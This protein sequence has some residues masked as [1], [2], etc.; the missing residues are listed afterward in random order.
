MVD[1]RVTNVLRLS[2]GGS[3]EKRRAARSRFLPAAD[4]V[5][6]ASWDQLE[7]FWYYG[8]LEA[9]Q[10]PNFPKE[11]LEAYCAE[12]CLAAREGKPLKSY[13][14]SYLFSNPSLP[15]ES[16]SKF[17][18]E[19]NLDTKPYGVYGA[20]SA[21]IRKCLSNSNCPEKWLVVGANNGFPEFRSAVA[22]NK[23]IPVKLQKLLLRDNLMSVRRTLIQNPVVSSELL[24]LA[25]DGN[26]GTQFLV[27][28]AKRVSGNDLEKVL[29]KLEAL[30]KPGTQARSTIAK[31]TSS[32]E[33]LRRLAYDPSPMVRAK[34]ISNTS[35]DDE[36]KVVVGLFG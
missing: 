23:A 5:F 16:I 9:I 18:E 31:L 27:S 36:M 33:S 13:Y 25:V 22:S 26:E 3:A 6:L 14:H 10:N 4:L 17:L 12:I 1:Q 8:G 15:P 34:V 30:R 35:A 32:Q 20:F 2:H 21:A 28:L 7:S 19:M 24:S 11:T 29:T